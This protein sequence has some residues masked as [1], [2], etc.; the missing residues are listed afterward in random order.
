[1]EKVSII[2]SLVSLIAW[3]VVY[4]DLKDLNDVVQELIKGNE[5]QIDANKQV[6]EAL[7]DSNNKNPRGVK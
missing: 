7:K 3:V 4:F 6:I 5:K 2:L 1:M